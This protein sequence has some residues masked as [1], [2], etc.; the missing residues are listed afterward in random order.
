MRF[1]EFPILQRCCTVNSLLRAVLFPVG[2]PQAHGTY[3]RAVATRLL[4]QGMASAMPVPSPCE[5]DS[6]T[7]LNARAQLM[8]RFSHKKA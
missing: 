8:P 2:G 6:S 1:G 3:K 4:R 5:W 7:L